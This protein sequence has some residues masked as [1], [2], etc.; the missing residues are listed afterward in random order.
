MVSNFELNFNFHIR[1]NWIKYRILSAWISYIK[2]D[3][4]YESRSRHQCPM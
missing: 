1:N 4:E 2:E 3:S